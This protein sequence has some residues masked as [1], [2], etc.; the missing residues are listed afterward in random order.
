[1]MVGRLGVLN[2][3]S[4]YEIFNLLGSNPTVKSRKICTDICY[5]IDKCQKHCTK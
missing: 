4:A 1:M 3:L 5:H 2:E